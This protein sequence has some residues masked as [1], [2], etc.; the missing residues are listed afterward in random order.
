MDI[1]RLMVAILKAAW[2]GG[3]TAPTVGTMKADSRAIPDNNINVLADASTTAALVAATQGA[4]DLPIASVKV[5]V[6]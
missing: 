5:T 1:K 3:S 4:L 2:P 6:T